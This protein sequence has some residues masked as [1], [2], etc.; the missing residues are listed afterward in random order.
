[1]GR[2][3]II[4]FCIGFLSAGGQN[5]IGLPEMVSFPKEVYQAG[6]QNWKI[7]QDANGIMY[8]P[9]MKDC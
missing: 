7:D 4:F 1:M 8:F 3:L 9:T 2:F 5:T 6:T